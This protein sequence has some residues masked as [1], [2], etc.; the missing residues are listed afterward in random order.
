M[1][2]LRLLGGGDNTKGSLSKHVLVFLTY[3][4]VHRWAAA[5]SILQLK[6]LGA[7]VSMTLLPHPSWLLRLQAS[8]AVGEGGGREKEVASDILV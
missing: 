5:G 7:G 8:C 4:E 3:Q 2:I 1:S 6:A